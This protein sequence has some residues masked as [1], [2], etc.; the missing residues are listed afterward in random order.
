MRQLLLTVSLIFSSYLLFAQQTVTVKVKDVK[1]GDPVTSASVVVK[2]TG[3]GASTNNDGVFIIQVK[4][5]DVLEVTSV[6]Y[7]PQLVKL[8]GSNEITVFLEVASLDLGDIVVI[9][10]RG[11]A[12]AKTETAVP[13]DVIKINQ[14]GL[15]TAKMDLTSVLNMTAPSFNYNKQSGADGAD[16]VDLGTLRGLGPDQTLVLINGKRR[17]STAFV[18][19]FGTRG[20]GASGSDLNAFPQ[21]AVD[22]IEILRDGASA[23]YGSD[24]MAGVMNIILK[25]DINHWTINT[26][27]AGYYDNKFN[28]SKFNEGNQ[29]YSGNKIDGGTFTFSANNGF[30]LGKNGGFIN[31]S[32]D[33]LTQNKTY[34][35]VDTTNW[36]TDKYALPYINSGRRAFGDGSVKTY[37]TMYNMEIP[38]KDTKTVFYSF[39]SVNQKESDAFAYSRNLSAKPKRFPTSAGGAPIFVP[40]IMRVSNDGETYY[41]PH[42]GTNINDA[43]IALGF[44][45]ISTKNW[46]WDVSLT[47]GKNDFQYFGDKTFNASLI[48]NTEKTYFLDGGFRFRQA[49]LNVDLSKSFKTVAQGLN[50]GYGFEYR[51]EKYTINKGEEASYAAYPNSYDLAPGAQGFPGFSPADVVDARRYNFSA[52]GDA[53]LNVTDKWLVDGAV[54]LETYSDFGSVAT[55]KFATR[56][57]VADNFNLRGSVSTGFRAPSLQ[58]INFSNTLTSFSNGQLVQ[59]RVLRN[60]DPITKSIGIPDLKEETSLNASLGFAWKPVSGFTVTVDGYM[61]KVKDRVVLSGLFSQGDP[62]LPQ[63]FNDQLAALGVSTAQ[64]FTNAVNTTNYGADVVA[65][66]TKKWANH[67]FKILLAGNFQDI[68]LDK[69]NVPAALSTTTLNKNTFYSDREIAFLKASA[70]K[71]K[72]NLNLEYGCGKLG[73]GTHLTYFG[74]IKLLGFGDSTPDNPYNSGINPMV[75]S[76]ANGTY[77]PE[78]FDYKGKLVTD[79]FASYKFCNQ[80]TIFIGADNI[81]NVHPNLGVNP[82]AKGW[83]GDNESGGPWDSVQMGFNGMKLFT[84]LVLNF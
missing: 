6:G 52:Y 68:K 54:R 48:G 20:R 7:K 12:R 67:S 57:K 4:A 35:Q 9:G 82:L 46:N 13:V 30:G 41:N 29:Y 71:A 78:V 24:A 21:N 11:A 83:A 26:G 84:K 55:F 65:D 10:T 40:G 1:T 61:I 64:F 43:S 27:W 60:G 59:S 56:Y 70:P 45:G 31:F 66:Y 15:P 76:D 5:S 14:A 32:L 23:Q 8:N 74:G 17:H 3:K 39:G 25:K 18:A 2:S 22:R 58:Q 63:S 38:V 16:H 50:I 72:F 47:N 28:T 81:L 75:P 62:S 19:L 77:V 33:Y 49:T 51:N 34:R 73:F 37:G 79:L 42:I 69:I 44:R 80:A 36:Q 53:E